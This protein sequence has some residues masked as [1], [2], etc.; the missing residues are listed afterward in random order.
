V[1]AAAGEFSCVFGMADTSDYI[2]SCVVMSHPPC[3]R[4][5]VFPAV[6]IFI[7]ILRVMTSV[8]NKLN[9]SVLEEHTVSVFRFKASC[10]MVI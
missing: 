4:A 5:E 3:T 8:V 10:V 2:S 1:G 6:N 7:A 9:V